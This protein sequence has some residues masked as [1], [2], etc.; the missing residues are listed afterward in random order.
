MAGVVL[1]KHAARCAGCISG[2]IWPLHGWAAD[3]VQHG[4]VYLA[5]APGLSQ[6]VDDCPFVELLHLD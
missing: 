2:A 4:V 6:V 1:Y 3:L 5:V